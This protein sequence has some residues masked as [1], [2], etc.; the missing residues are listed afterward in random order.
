MPGGASRL[1]APP[2]GLGRGSTNLCRGLTRAFARRGGYACRRTRPAETVRISR[3]PGAPL[4]TV[5]GISNF[6]V[7]MRGSDGLLAALGTDSPPA[8]V[9]RHWAL[10]PVTSAVLAPPFSRRRWRSPS[11]L[12][13][14]RSCPA[15]RKAFG[16][17]IRNPAPVPALGGRHPR[18]PPTTARWCLPA[19]HFVWQGLP[20]SGNLSSQD[21]VRPRRVKLTIFAQEVEL[22]KNV[23]QL[24]VT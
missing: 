12:T 24:M 8:T 16:A 2:A 22:T 14:V 11:P 13:S 19:L 21:A 9:T 10:G 15:R 1:W 5:G 4:A 17:T 20:I 18:A 23:R 7:E 6:A 3:V